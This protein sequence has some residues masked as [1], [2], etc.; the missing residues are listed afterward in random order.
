MV[1]CF[2]GDP[3]I[4]RFDHSP[5][6]PYPGQ[7]PGTHVPKAQFLYVWTVGSSFSNY[8]DG[9]WKENWLQTVA[10]KGER[11]SMEHGVEE[12]SSKLLWMSP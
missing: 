10:S 11:V 4:L 2:F 8:G 7:P 6:L 9:I 12:R 5:P 1:L 3:R